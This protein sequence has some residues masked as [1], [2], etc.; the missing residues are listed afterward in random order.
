VI[1][2]RSVHVSGGV[3]LRDC[4]APVGIGPVRV[5]M[6]R[7]FGLRIDES[8]VPGIRS[9]V[10][11]PAGGVKATAG[12]VKVTAGGVRAGAC[13]KF[14]ML[15]SLTPGERCFLGFLRKINLTNRP[16][17]AERQDIAKSIYSCSLVVMIDI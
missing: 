12:R 8:R 7:R 3:V 10:E 16:K 17:A 1:G 6:G 9:A 2:E 5:M 4:S 13:D 14:A 15:G 11:A